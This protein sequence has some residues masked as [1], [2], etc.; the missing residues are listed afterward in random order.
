MSSKL[1]IWLSLMA[2]SKWIKSM[3]PTYNYKLV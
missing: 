1:G 3:V 2:G